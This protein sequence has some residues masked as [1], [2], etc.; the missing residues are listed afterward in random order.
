MPG[1]SLFTIA[2]HHLFI[3]IYADLVLVR[4]EVIGVSEE[5]MVAASRIRLQPPFSTLA[6]RALG[7]SP[8]WWFVLHQ[9]C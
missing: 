7:D 2:F 3:P 6:A 9:G 1:Q 5:T 4:G 8:A